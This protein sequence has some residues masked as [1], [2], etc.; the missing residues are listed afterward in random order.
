MDTWSHAVARAGRAVGG[1]IKPGS[2]VVAIGT[3]TTDADGTVLAGGVVAHQVLVTSVQVEDDS[4]EPSR[5]ETQTVAPA[6]AYW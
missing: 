2:R 3:P 1:L 5:D 4:G 6:Q